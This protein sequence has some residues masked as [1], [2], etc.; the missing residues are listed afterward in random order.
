MSVMKNAHKIKCFFKFV[1][2]LYTYEKMG[3]EQLSMVVSFNLICNVKM[4]NFIESPTN[5]YIKMSGDSHINMSI[6]ISKCHYY[7]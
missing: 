5:I 4:K 7:Y 3:G 6:F 1:C 2:F